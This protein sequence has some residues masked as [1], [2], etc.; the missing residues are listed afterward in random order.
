MSSLA[1]ASDLARGIAVSYAVKELF[2]SLQGEGCHTGRPAIFIR[3]AGCN[4]W[5]GREDSRPHAVCRFCDTDFVG[6]DGTFGG[7][8]GAQA[9]AEQASALWQERARPFA[10]LTGGEPALQL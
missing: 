8:Y 5:N 3:F 2:A 7:R 1:R 9:L 4:L 10:V 6:T